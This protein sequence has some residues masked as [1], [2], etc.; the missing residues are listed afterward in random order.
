MSTF[1]SPRKGMETEFKVLPTRKETAAYM[2]NIYLA[3]QGDGN[4]SAYL[5]VYLKAF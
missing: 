3:P 5:E 4:P 2:V 1:T